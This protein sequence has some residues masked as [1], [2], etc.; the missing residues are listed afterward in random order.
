MAL[1]YISDSNTTTDITASF[2]VHKCSVLCEIYLPE[3]LQIWPG[4]AASIRR[5]DGGLFLLADIV[6][7]V[8]RNDSVLDVM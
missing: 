2:E 1:L 6:H 5:T 7:K 3:R 4:Y 8:I